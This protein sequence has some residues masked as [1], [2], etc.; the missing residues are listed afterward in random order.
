MRQFAPRSRGEANVASGVH[1]P[2]VEGALLPNWDERPIS[3]QA[4]PWSLEPEMRRLGD[5][6][7]AKVTFRAAHEGAPG[8]AHGG[9]VAALFDDILGAVLSVVGLGA[10]TGELSVRYA[11][12]TPLHRELLC[13]CRLTERD[14]RKLYMTGELTDQGVNICTTKATFIIPKT[15][16][17]HT[18]FGPG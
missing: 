3:G 16:F 8:R 1:V 12:P 17:T 9:L 10:F 6:V 14:G 13:T 5:G 11:A 7:V 15:P 4:S 18:T 2:P